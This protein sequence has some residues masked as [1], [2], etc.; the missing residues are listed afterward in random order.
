[1]LSAIGNKKATPDIIGDSYLPVLA[2]IVA[3]ARIIFTLALN[4]V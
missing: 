4:Q 3:L 2:L 1:M